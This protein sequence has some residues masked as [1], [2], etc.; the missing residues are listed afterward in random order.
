MSHATAWAE[1]AQGI[2]VRGW[3]WPRYVLSPYETE[4]NSDNSV[5]EGRYRPRRPGQATN[6][7]GCASASTKPTGPTHHG[8][9]E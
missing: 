5:D 4:E 7:R 3:T 1:V 2:A 6:G 9:S 8:E